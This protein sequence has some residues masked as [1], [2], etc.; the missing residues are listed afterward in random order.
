[1]TLPAIKEDI[2]ATIREILGPPAL[3]PGEDAATYEATLAHFA[4]E[5]APRDL[6]AWML[7]KDL[8]DHRLEIARYRRIRAALVR[9]QSII[10]PKTMDREAAVQVPSKTLQLID[11]IAQRVRRRGRGEPAGRMWRGRCRKID[12]EYCG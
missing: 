8:A 5:V 6:I 4:R 10:A 9:T 11:G 7:I 3:L 12:R 2:P 1:M